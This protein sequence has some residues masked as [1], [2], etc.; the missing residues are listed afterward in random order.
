MAAMFAGFLSLLKKAFLR[1]EVVGRL[2]MSSSRWGLTE[3]LVSW[4]NVVHCG[5]GPMALWPGVQGTH[6]WG[7]IFAQLP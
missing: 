5:A 6:L 7:C 2:A 4:A 1:Q 3:S